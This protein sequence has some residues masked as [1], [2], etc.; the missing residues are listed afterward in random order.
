MK[1]F[2]RGDS[3]T[4]TKEQGGSRL[5]AQ[6]EKI[7]QCKRSKFAVVALVA[8]MALGVPALAKSTHSA[9]P[10]NVASLS[11]QGLNAE[12]ERVPNAHGSVR[13]APT[14]GAPKPNNP[15]VTGAGSGA[16]NA[17]LYVY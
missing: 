4:L 13:R 3:I 5:V 15:T 8:A 16:Y 2:Q 17:G 7:M 11:T 14:L 10:K 1:E 9:K 6:K 12:R